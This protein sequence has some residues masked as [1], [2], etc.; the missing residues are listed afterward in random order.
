MCWVAELVPVLYW[1]YILTSSQDRVSGE[2]DFSPLSNCNR[3]FNYKLAVLTAL[4]KKKTQQRF[5]IKS[6]R[7]SISKADPSI[8][9]WSHPYLCVCIHMWLLIIKCQSFVLRFLKFDPWMQIPILV[10]LQSALGIMFECLLSVEGWN[11][12]SW[13]WRA[14]RALLILLFSQIRCQ[15]SNLCLQQK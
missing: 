5:E 13:S 3:A 10:K 4:G 12:E 2:C 7:I 9:A 6:W 11:Q 14:F 1:L 8:S 15:G